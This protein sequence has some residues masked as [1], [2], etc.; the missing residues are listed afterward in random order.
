LSPLAEILDRLVP[1]LGALEGE[2][3]PLQGGITN[4]NYLTRLGGADYVVRLPGKDTEQLGIDRQ[5]EAAANRCAARAGIAPEVAAF[6][7]DPPCLVTGFVHGQEMG[8]A[9]LRGPAARAHVA[10]ALH[11]IHDCGERLPS[12]FSA[13]RVGEAYAERA[14]RRGGA[15]P[16]AYGPAHQAAAQIERALQRGE[17]PV[18][19][20]NDLLA[21]NFLHSNAGIRLVDWEYAGMGDRYF[22]LGN[23]AVNNELGHDEEIAF[24][25]AYF[26]APAGPARLAALRLMRFMS[27]FR[28]AMWAVLQ[29]TLSDLEFDF[30]HYAAKHFA[31]LEMTA[32]DP[33]FET[34]LQEASRLGA[35]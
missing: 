30:E 12:E 13:L 1:L 6:L 23:F 26:A 15:V 17:D 11:A 8:P 32:A 9:E 21:A 5:A 3:T 2:P 27:D 24:L 33:Y 19:C 34:W 22:D 29:G 7:D 18:P 14:R 20:H 10:A 4:R 25:D 16:D 28:E 35:K 31:R